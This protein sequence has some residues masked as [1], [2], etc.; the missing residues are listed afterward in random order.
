MPVDGSVEATK[1]SAARRTR[2]LIRSPVG[3]TAG[4]AI[5]TAL[6]P[7]PI[8]WGC[9][10]VEGVI[11]VALNNELPQTVTMSPSLKE[12]GATRVILTIGSNILYAD[13]SV[14]A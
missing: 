9:N 2:K 8:N 7:T 11:K 14:R 6:S 1:V 12:A 3:E 5:S 13:S 4:S 10:D